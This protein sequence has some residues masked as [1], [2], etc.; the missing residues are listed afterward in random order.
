[1]T[2]CLLGDFSDN[3]DE[4]FKNTS[5]YLAQA[6]SCRNQVV[7]LN[8]KHMNKAG[9]W[10]QLWQCRPTI[11][12][13][14]AQPTDHS[15][16]FIYLA[17]KR[18]PQVKTVLSTLRAER[19][20]VN[21]MIQPWQRFFVQRARPDLVCVQNEIGES[22]F[23]S[24]GC[25]VVYL[26]N[27]VDL[28]R[29][30]PI[31]AFRKQELRIQYSLDPARPVVLHVGHLEAARNLKTLAPLAAAGIQVVIAGSLYMGTNQALID[32][33]EAAGFHIFKGYQPQIEELYQLSDCYVFPPHPGNSLSMPLSVLEAMACDLPVVTTRFSGLEAA[34]TPGQG[35][36]FVDNT[37]ALLP[38]VLQALINDHVANTRQLVAPYSWRAIAEQLETYY[39]TLLAGNQPLPVSRTNRLQ[40]VADMESDL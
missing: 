6:L 22:M 27:G 25:R 31:T 8:V 37:E 10:Q 19:Y 32:Q 23:Q 20:F 29:F 40:K 35:M 39:Q 16:T 11:L 18:W 34:F 24:L 36:T 38:H 9:F 4:G 5:H 13:I 1:M 12:H 15:F 21:G 14:I 33:L 2:I 7:T 28:S 30:R 26:G 17:K 3:L